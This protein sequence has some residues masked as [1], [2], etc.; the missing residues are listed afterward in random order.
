MHPLDAVVKRGP[1]LENPAEGEIAC[2]GPPGV[3][4]SVESR[5]D[6]VA[7][8]SEVVADATCAGFAAALAPGCSPRLR[9]PPPLVNPDVRISR[10]RLPDWVHDLAL[11]DRPRCAYRRQST[12]SSP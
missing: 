8:G 9:L 11:A 5:A 2:S 6:A 1:R 12:P 10:I 3:A 7:G 4:S